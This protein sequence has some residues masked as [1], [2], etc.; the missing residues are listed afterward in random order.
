MIPR[1]EKRLC[2]AFLD[3]RRRRTHGIL[4]EE[5]QAAIE[6]SLAPSMGG[7]TKACSLQILPPI[8][9]HMSLKSSR[10][11]H[12][13]ICF[14]QVAPAVLRAMDE[15]AASPGG[16]AEN[17]SQRNGEEVSVGTL[18]TRHHFCS[19]GLRLDVSYLTFSLSFLSVAAS[20]EAQAWQLDQREEEEEAD[21][22]QQRPQ[23]PPHGL[24]P[25]YERQAGAAAGGAAGRALPRDNQ[26]AGQRV[27]QAAP[28]GEA[29][30]WRRVRQEVRSAARVTC[31]RDRC[32]DPC[33]VA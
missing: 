29:S 31:R 7:V 19:S 27:E 30:Q 12:L 20:T 1:R 13:G 4:R 32:V 11:P 21:E 16:N 2:G 25:L 23:G 5:M 15:Q 33:G 26:D 3:S 6:R 8:D 28:R 14:S 9:H 18:A 10:V 22:G 24:R 17:N